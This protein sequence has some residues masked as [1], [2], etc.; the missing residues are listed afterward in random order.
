M[1]VLFTSHASL[2]RAAQE[3]RAALGSRWPILV[4]GEAPRD[5]LLRRFREAENAILLGTDS[6]W[7]GA[8]G[9][10]GT[11]RAVTTG[12]ERSTT[13]GANIGGSTTGVIAN[14]TCVANVAGSG[15]CVPTASVGPSPI[16]WGVLNVPGAP[17]PGGQAHAPGFSNVVLKLSTDNSGAQTK[18]LGL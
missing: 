17:N 1:F 6:F 15:D 5:V 8:A 16:L 10:G 11:P 4:Q 18:I 13:M 3:T 9:A 7:A 14:W 2:R 12:I